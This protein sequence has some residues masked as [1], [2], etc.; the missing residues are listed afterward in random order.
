MNKRFLL[1]S[2][3]LKDLHW[4]KENIQNLF[5]V[6][7]SF[8]FKK[9]IYTD[10]STSGW[11]AV[12]QRKRTKGFWSLKERLLHINT[13]EILAAFSGLKCF[14][15]NDCN[16]QILLRIDNSTA[17]AYINKTGGIRFPHLNK[18]SREIWEWCIKR[19]ISGLYCFKRKFSWLR[20]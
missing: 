7:R 16:S 3:T 6:I 10:A 2:Q 9:E 18:L 8:N 17:I 11:G 20:F 19:D 14:V 12:C 1:N 15:S 4:W 5:N 13:L